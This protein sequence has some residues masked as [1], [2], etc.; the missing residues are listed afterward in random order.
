VSPKRYNNARN[1][2]Q[3]ASYEAEADEIMIWAGWYWRLGF[4]EDADKHRKMAE[5][6]YEF[7]KK[8]RGGNK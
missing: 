8:L 1:L 5:D 4:K 2:T 3:A 6:R 7:A